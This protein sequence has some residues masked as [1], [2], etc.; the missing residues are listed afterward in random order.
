M[1]DISFKKKDNHIKFEAS[2]EIKINQYIGK[3][4]KKF[5]E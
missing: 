4:N 2:D 5:G 1:I 3:E